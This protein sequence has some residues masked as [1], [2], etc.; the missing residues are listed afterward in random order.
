[1]KRML[2]LLFLCILLC[3]C[4]AQQ[5]PSDVSGDTS[6]AA[7]TSGSGGTRSD[8]AISLLPD[9]DRPAYENVC[10]TLPTDWEVREPG[11]GG[12]LFSARSRDGKRSVSV[13]ITELTLTNG[14]TQELL[15]QEARSSLVSAWKDAGASEVKADVRTVTFLGQETDALFLSAFSDGEAVFQKQLYRS[16]DGAVYL[17][18]VTSHVSDETDTLL[19]AFHIK[20]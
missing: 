1:M 5:D 8:G 10:F 6:H 18:T 3:G 11:Q 14:L 20:A 17:V 15:L 9:P 2:C 4:H 12:E 19:Q 7:G 16:H 13:F